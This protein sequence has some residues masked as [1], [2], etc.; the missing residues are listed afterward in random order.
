MS[1][2]ATCGA[3]TADDRDFCGNCGAYL[4][5]DEPEEDEAPTA[6]LVETPAVSPDPP[7]AVLEVEAPETVE[8]TEAVRVTLAAVDDPGAELGPPS[9]RVEPGGSARL[10]GTVFNQSGIVDSFHLRIAGL[11]PSWWTIAPST[12]NLMPF[13]S[14]EGA[15]DQQVEVHIHPPRSFEAEARAWEI[16]LVARSRA[17]DSDSAKAAGTL[18]IAP[19]AQIECRVIP[20]TIRDRRSGKLVLPVRNLGNA[21]ADV[22]FEAEDDEGM[23]RFAFSPVALTLP[24]GAEGHSEATVTARSGVRGSPVHR[25]LTV[26]AVSGSERVERPATFIQEPEVK[27]SYRL[28]WRVALTL[29]AALLLLGGAV[30][31]WDGAGNQGLC[32]NGY[33][34]CL[35]YDVYLEQAGITSDLDHPEPASAVRLIAAVTSVGV[36]AVLFAVF[37]LIGARRGGLTWMAGCLAILLAIGMLLSLDGP[38]IGV[39]IVLLGG[40]FAVAAGALARG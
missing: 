23:L 37:A 33:S 12:V 25:R 36:L 32:T 22:A 40:V 17:H 19:F 35:S 26:A 39:W 10:T 13:G 29:L 2:C 34:E 6:V 21:P 15:P 4:R 1:E 9:V 30:A 3:R 7:T 16:A 5:W 20:Q 38:A 11:D 8:P 18:T 28:H 24:A 14:P 31:R 27:R